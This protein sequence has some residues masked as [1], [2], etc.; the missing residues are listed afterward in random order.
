MW[1]VEIYESERGWGQRLV[2]TREFNEYT[3]AK[4]FYE[5]TNAKNNL[6]TAP[7]LYEFARIPYFV[8]GVV[9]SLKVGD[10]VSVIEDTPHSQKSLG[11]LKSDIKLSIEQILG[12][13]AMVTPWNSAHETMV[14]LSKLRKVE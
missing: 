10:V 7:V 8:E 6:P 14:L 4:K 1:K 13:V 5:E 3:D 11:V 9:S 2:E 12:N